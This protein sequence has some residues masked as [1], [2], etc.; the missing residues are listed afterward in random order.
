MQSSHLNKIQHTQ[1]SWNLYFIYIRTSKTL[2]WNW[3]RQ[4]FEFDGRNTSQK[5]LPAWVF[6]SPSGFLPESKNISVRPTNNSKLSAGV[7]VDDCL[8]HKYKMEWK[9]ACAPNKAKSS[10][11]KIKGYTAWRCCGQHCRPT[12][13]KVSHL[14]PRSG[15]LYDL[16]TSIL[17]F[18]FQVFCFLPTGWEDWWFQS[19][20]W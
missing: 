11:N 4:R 10:K 20:C 18:F 17:D 16:L 14:N 15:S 7:S 6:S 2:K 5:K 12:A 3:D 9:L 19:K 8:G 1:T 13:K